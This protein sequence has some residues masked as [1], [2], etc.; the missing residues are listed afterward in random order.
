MFG[1][2][3]DWIMDHWVQCLCVF[4][5]IVAVSVWGVAFTQWTMLPQCTTIAEYGGTGNWRNLREGAATYEIV[6]GVLADCK[7]SKYLP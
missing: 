4:I 5:L 7:V 6:G 1:R 2:L 3:N